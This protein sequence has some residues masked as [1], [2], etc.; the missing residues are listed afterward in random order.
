VTNAPLPHVVDGL[1]LLIDLDARALELDR[2]E[3]EARRAALTARKRKRRWPKPK[4]R[5]EDTTHA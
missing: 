4:K 1:L 2:A 3:E 5:V